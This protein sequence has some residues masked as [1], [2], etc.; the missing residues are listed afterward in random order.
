VSEGIYMTSFKVLVTDLGLFLV[1]IPSVLN[2]LG[3]QGLHFSTVN[4]IANR[5]AEVS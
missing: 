4:E 3:Y 2:S 1:R 5:V